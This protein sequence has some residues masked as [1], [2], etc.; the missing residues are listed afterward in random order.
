MWTGTATFDVNNATK[1]D[2]KNLSLTTGQGWVMIIG[3]S[4]YQTI[5]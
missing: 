2:K 5:L 4:I 1:N 3:S